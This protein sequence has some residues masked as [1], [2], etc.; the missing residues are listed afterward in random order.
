MEKYLYFIL[1]LFLS[2]WRIRKISNPV[3][4]SG[5]NVN[6]FFL[7]YFPGIER[8]WRKNHF[9]MYGGL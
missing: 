1:S 8:E 6:N 7:S 4:L 9:D 2:L 3:L 5:Y